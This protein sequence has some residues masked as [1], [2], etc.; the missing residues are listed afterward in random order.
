MGVMEDAACRGCN[1]GETSPFYG[2]FYRLRLQNDVFG[3]FLLTFSVKLGLFA[4][5]FLTT[6][7]AGTILF[8][9]GSKNELFQFYPY[10]SPTRR[11]WPLPFHGTF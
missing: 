3:A 7:S 8:N 9:R 10:A 1:Q 6:F 4:A 5:A 2:G 11:N